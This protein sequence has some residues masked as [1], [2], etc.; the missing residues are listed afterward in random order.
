MSLFLIKEDSVF[1][2]MDLPSEPWKL[3][4]YFSESDRHTN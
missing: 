4:D 1:Y 3:L 2:Y